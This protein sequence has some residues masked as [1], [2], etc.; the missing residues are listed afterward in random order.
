V[1]LPVALGAGALAAATLAHGTYYRNSSVFGHAI[2]HLPGNVPRVA[3][4]FD[5]GPNPETTPRVLDAL[6]AADVKAT[7]FLLGRHVDRWPDLA[8]RVA[9]EGHTVANHGWYHRKLHVRSSGYVRD[10]IARGTASIVAATGVVPAFFRAPHG[11]R[12][13]WV[14]RAA[15]AFGQQVVGW[16]LGVWDTALPG[17][18]VIAERSLAGSHPGTILLLHDGDGYDMA[19]DRTQTADALPIILRGYRDRGL[20]MVPLASLDAE[21]TTRDR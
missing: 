4:T 5:D 6:A 7:F 19:G 12:S 13:P 9:T 21:V 10:D 11:F 14:N 15:A 2:G 3:I 16:S 17:A 18:S 20:A 8:R 1:I